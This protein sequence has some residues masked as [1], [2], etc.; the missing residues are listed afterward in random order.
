MQL[1]LLHGGRRD[2][3]ACGNSYGAHYERRSRCEDRTLGLPG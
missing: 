1:S 2:E 3:V